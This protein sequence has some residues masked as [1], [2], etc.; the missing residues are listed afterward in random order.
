MVAFSPS[1]AAQQAVSNGAGTN[2]ARIPQA[3]IAAQNT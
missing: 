1:L 3:V 2:Y